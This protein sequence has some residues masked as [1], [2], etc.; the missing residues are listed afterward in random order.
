[1]ARVFITGSSDGLGRM[2][3]QLL[4]EQGHSA[5]LH[6]RNEQRGREALSAVPGAETVIIADLASIAQ[7]RHLAEQVNALGSF[8]AVIHNA[9]V[10]YREPRPIETEDGLPHVFAANTLAPYILT[11]LIKKPKRLV[12]LSS[13]LHRN[14]DASLKDLAWK[15]R[16][17]NGQQAYSDTKLHDVLLAFALARRW[18]DVLSNALEPG[19]VPTKMGGPGAPDDLD[20]AHRTQ[21]WLAASNDP[22][23]MVTGEYFYHMRLRAPSPV[24]R[25]GKLQDALLDAC[26]NFSGVEFPSK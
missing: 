8:D 11:A 13:G 9:A 6:A 18:P 16:P 14:G 17:W 24:S 19:W 4:I 25:D 26:K 20:A 1:M 5:V 3:A 21:V 2:A 7:T 10:G 22:A 12:Y 15:E 23:A